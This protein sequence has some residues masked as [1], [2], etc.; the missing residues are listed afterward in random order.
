MNFFLASLLRLMLLFFLSRRYKVEVRGLE[1]I[2]GNGHLLLANHVSAL[3][4]SIFQVF[5]WKRFKARPFATSRFTSVSYLKPM[6]KLIRAITVPDCTVAKNSVKVLQLEKAYQE[7]LEGLKNGDNILFYPA[8]HLKIS[9][10]EKLGGQSGLHTLLSKDPTLKLVLVRTTGLWGS[11]FSPAPHGRTPDLKEEVLNGLKTW[12]KFYLFPPKRHVLIELEPY[13][14]SQ[15]LPSKMELNRQLEAWYNLPT[16]GR[17]EPVYPPFD[18]IPFFPETMKGEMTPLEKKV[19]E[20]VALLAGCPIEEIKKE[21]HIFYDLG[22]DSLQ[23]TELFD[24]L[25]QKYSVS[26]LYSPELITPYHIALQIEGKWRSP[27]YLHAIEKDKKKFNKLTNQKV[28]PSSGDDLLIS[29]KKSTLRYALFDEFLGLLTPKK[30]LE[31]IEAGTS[32]AIADP[33]DVIPILFPSSLERAVALL[34][35]RLAG[36]QC[37]LLSL[38]E[39]K[40]ISGPIYSSETMIREWHGWDIG[41]ASE[42]VTDLFSFK[43]KKGGKFTAVSF[44][45]GQITPP[46]AILKDPSEEQVFE[47]LARQVPI[48]SGRSHWMDQVLK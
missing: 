18:P 20:T 13:T 37:Q 31:K 8:G 43:F 4:A 23:A 29:L 40:E 45:G 34:S 5:T 38:T 7:V 26:H 17:G 12:F 44:K 28:T 46:L 14:L 10:T 1:R 16:K 25:E 39:A 42:Q 32:K 27:R 6:F 41:K 48:F 15:P 35:I 47:A 19:A 33:R 2:E 9:G 22:L 3:D 36:K 30:L 21:T 24:L 11:R